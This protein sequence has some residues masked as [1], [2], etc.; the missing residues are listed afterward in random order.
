[1][2]AL[3]S[4]LDNFTPSQIGEN[5][6]CEYTWSNNV[7]ERILQLSFQLTRARD[8]TNINSLAQQTDNILKELTSSYKASIL[9]REEY[10]AYMSIMYRMIGHTRDIIDG[11]GEYALSYMLLSVWYNH[12]PELAKFVFR[13]FV[14]PLPLEAGEDNDL[15]PY[16][17]W[18]DIKHLYKRNKQSPLVQYGSQLLLEQLRTDST[19]DNPSL[20]AKWVP[21]EKSQFGDLFTELAIDYFCDYIASAK[22]SDARKRAIIKA[23]M[24]FRKLISSLNKKLD[25]VQ[26]KQ[27]AHHW[28]EIEPSKQTSITMHKQKKAFLNVKKDGSQ[29]SELDDRV[30]CANKFKEFAQKAVDGEVEVKG[31]RI[32][33]NDF[34]EEALELIGR[35]QQKSVEAD[36][37]NAQWI[38]NSKQTGALGKMI[39]MVDVSGSMSGNP[40]N[41]AIALGIRVAEKSM[42]GKRIMTFSATPTWVN[43]TG[44]DTFIEMVDTIRRADWGMNTN[45]AA[46][47]KMIL[48]CIVTQKLSPE[49]VEDMVLAI[50]SDMQMDQADPK[51][52]SLMET[53]ENMY[54]EAGQRLWGRPFKAPHI[55]FWN[56]RST[57]GFPSLSTQKN[58]SMMSG[59]SPALLNLFCEEGLSALQ[60][61]TPWSL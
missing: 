15:H 42:L 20:A 61:C 16:G 19:S 45:F 28:S 21:R 51:S 31:K 39:A 17:S 6:S 35:N 47:L 23:K 43:L 52:R 54:T 46:A 14:V 3:I 58:A 10:I 18:K 13:L 41:A 22:T 48:D 33:L 24:D 29:R 40:M 7:R 36:I 5:G 37:L 50:F 30:A 53:I 59:F 25:T 12:H 11:K 8:E 55:L 56:L 26:I 60:S 44:Q 32:G 2:S 49:D 57:S 9:S 27:C 34:T 1:M 4:A 38:D